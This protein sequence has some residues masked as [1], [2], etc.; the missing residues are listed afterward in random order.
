DRSADAIQ[1]DAPN[2]SDLVL[3]SALVTAKT[4][5]VVSQL[6]LDAAEKLFNAGGASMTGRKH[7]FDRHWRSLRTLFSHNPLLHKARV[8]GDY[9]LNGTTTH[10][11]EGKVF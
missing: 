3:E 11:L 10:L 2:A 1:A 8:V 5:L 6:A 7:N 9:H 4:Q